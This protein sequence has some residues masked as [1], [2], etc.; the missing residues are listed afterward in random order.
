MAEPCA[1]LRAGARQLVLVV[2]EVTKRMT[3]RQAECDPVAKGLPALLLDP[4]SLR[5]RSRHTCMVPVGGPIRFRL[6]G[7]IAAAIEARGLRKR[8][9]SVEALRGIDLTVETGT[10][11]GLLGP[12]G[13]GKRRRALSA[14][15]ATCPV[16][17]VG[18]DPA[19][20]GRRLHGSA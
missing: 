11:F 1:A 8:Y 5:P 17:R 14:R 19:D 13:A 20:D 18:P 2:E 12:N 6:L 15:V 10:V 3:A 4:V 7:R 16:V 9:G